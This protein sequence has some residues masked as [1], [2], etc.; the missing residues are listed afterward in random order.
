MSG[1][2]GPGNL[3]AKRGL[4][5][6]EAICK[7]HGA[8]VPFVDENGQP[9]KVGICHFCYEE[10]KNGEFFSCPAHGL[11]KKTASGGCP[12]P[13]CLGSGY[14]TSEDEI[15]RAAESLGSLW[16]GGPPKR[17]N[18]VD[19]GPAGPPSVGDR[20]AVPSA[21]GEP[22]EVPRDDA[23]GVEEGPARRDPVLIEVREMSVA[24][25]RKIPQASGPEWR[26]PFLDP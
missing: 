13:L 1:L 9:A 4:F 21:Q 17:E 3:F 22:R 20:E 12:V 23:Q 7:I 14:G 18:S 25:L 19:A 24:E 6:D 5:G 11:V 10:S 2:F 26:D 16:P 15:A 8:N